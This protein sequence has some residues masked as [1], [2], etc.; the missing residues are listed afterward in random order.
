MKLILPEALTPLTKRGRKR[1]LK[2]HDDGEPLLVARPEFP[3][4]ALAFAKRALQTQEWP[5]DRFPEAGGNYSLVGWLGER[6]ALLD[7]D[8]N[9]I[10]WCHPGDSFI[11]L[12]DKDEG[13]V[14]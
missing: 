13:G 14:S 2:S 12:K 5:A 9:R 4:A 10:G 3:A 11:S 6:G 7:R 8:G 1:V